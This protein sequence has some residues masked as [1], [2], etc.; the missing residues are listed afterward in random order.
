MAFTFKG[1]IWDLF[2]K[3]SYRYKELD[4][5]K[6]INGKGTFERYINTI[7]DEIDE[8][9]YPYIRDF[10]DI[11]DTLTV[12]SKYLPYISYFLGE[13][14]SANG[15]TDIY[16]KILAYAVR[17]YKIK[18][19]LESYQLLFNLYGLTVDIVEAMP[20][21]GATYDMVSVIYDDNWTYDQNCEHC[22]CYYIYYKPIDQAHNQLN[23]DLAI[24]LEIINLINRI[25]CFI[26]PINAK[27]CGIHRMITFEDTLELNMEDDANL[28]L[29]ER[30][31][32]VN[33]LA[34][35][36]G[37][38]VAEDIIDAYE[39][40]AGNWDDDLDQIL[41]DLQDIGAANAIR[42]YVANPD[43]SV[44]LSDWLYGVPIADVSS[45][46]NFIRKWFTLNCED[47]T[48]QEAG[49]Y[50]Y[51]IHPDGDQYFTSAINPD[52][53]VS[54]VR[55]LVDFD[56]LLPLDGCP[57][58][59]YPIGVYGSDDTTIGIAEDA[60]HFAQIWNSYAPNKEFGFIEHL[61]GCNFRLWRRSDED[62]NLPS[63]YLKAKLLTTGPDGDFNE[64]FT[65][66]PGGDFY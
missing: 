32:Y 50:L 24:P 21:K 31:Q 59:Q 38:P 4:T 6:D 22:T 45:L 56:T 29:T 43:G 11:F 28:T 51:P 3:G 19:T 36:V 33:L 39:L 53:L 9:I 17:I 47:S 63:M 34:P 15:D 41:S 12:D 14:P 52:A 5:N 44:T 42:F 30:I 10:M 16:R 58:P 66:Q 57:A 8:E 65:I 2:M 7:E 35:L 55:S 26:Q 13:P 61:S 49:D 37:T 60:D 27:L 46:S 40:G 54:Q 18:G 62:D 20:R 23:V 64:D 25:V 48:L 1:F